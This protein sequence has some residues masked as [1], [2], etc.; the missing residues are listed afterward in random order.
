M[1]GRDKA[2]RKQA[3]LC[4][5]PLEARY[6]I[7][8]LGIIPGR[9]HGGLPGGGDI[10]ETPAGFPAWSRVRNGLGGELGRGHRL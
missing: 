9:G 7:I 5:I 4:A 6:L 8:A 3:S 1:T 2:E 10:S